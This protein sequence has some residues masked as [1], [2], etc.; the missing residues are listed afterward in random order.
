M[1][2]RPELVVEGLLAAQTSL[3]KDQ[4]WG[5]RPATVVVAGETSFVGRFDGEGFDGAATVNVP[6]ISLVG[7]VA[8]DQR[9]MVLC[10]PPAGNY[11]IA[12][13]A[14]DGATAWVDYEAELTA[15]VS[16]PNLG[17]DGYIR[18]RWV[19]IAPRTVA[20]EVDISFAGAG[21]S[22]GSGQYFVGTPFQVASRSLTAAVGALYMFD[23]GTANRAGIVA[24][25]TSGDVYFMI[26]T[27]NGDVGATVPQTWAAGDAM[28]LSI[29]HEIESF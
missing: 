21:V 16:N 25:A 20:V 18:G 27:P 9:V 1:I 7:Y 17:A 19:E 14:S 4:R 12:R 24:V 11:A 2:T 10:V 15:T 26:N 6:M 5:L 3:D 29:I 23:S 8:P 13:V 28:R 22:A